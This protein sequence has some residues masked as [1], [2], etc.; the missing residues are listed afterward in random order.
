MVPMSFIRKLIQDAKAGHWT[1]VY[2]VL[3]LIAAG[4][5]IALLVT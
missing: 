4:I 2:L 1:A 5:F 3:E